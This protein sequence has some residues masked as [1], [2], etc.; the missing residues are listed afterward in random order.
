MKRI[1]F[2]GIKGIGKSIKEIRPGNIREKI[3]NN[4][5]KFAAVT[6][7][8]LA[9]IVGITAVRM[10]MPDG[11]EVSAATQNCTVMRQDLQK[12]L[13]VTGTIDGAGSYALSSPL[14]GVEVKSVNVKVGDRVRK[15]DVV[16][17]LDVS[18]VQNSIDSTLTGISANNEKNAM[19]IASA[20][21]SL[22]DAKTSADVANKR[23]QD[24]YEQAKADY[25]EAVKHRNGNSG[26]NGESGR[27]DADAAV[28]K[29]E[30]TVNSLITEARTAQDRLETLQKAYDDA[31]SDETK[32]ETDYNDAKGKY[33]GYKDQVDAQEKAV[34]D[35]E[36]GRDDALDAQD[37][38]EDNSGYRAYHAA[39]RTLRDA[40]SEL[41]SLKTKM[42]NAKTAMDKAKT[43]YDKA[44]VVTKDA[45]AAK[46][47]AEKK[48]EKIKYKQEDAESALS[49]AQTKQSDAKSD[50]DAVRSAQDNLTKASQ[51]V[52]D[53][54]RSGAKSVAE[55][56]D[57]IRS[58]ELSASTS[59]LSAQEELRKYREQAAKGVIV[60]LSDGV[61]TSLNVTE[62]G[63]YD[64]GTA[65][66][67][68]DDSG[69]KVSASI[70]QY[71]IA[72]ITTG[73]GAT[74]SVNNSEPLELAGNVTFVSPIPG[75]MAASSDGGSS[76]NAGSS[77][78]SSTSS[79]YPVEVMIMD[80]CDQLRLG[81]KVKLTI[82]LAEADD[83]LSVPANFIQTD[84][85][86][87]D[88]I[89]VVDGVTGSEDD[90]AEAEQPEEGA[91][92]QNTRIIYVTRGLETDYYVEISGDGLEENMEVVISD[93]TDDMGS[94]E[95][96]GDIAA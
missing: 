24:D 50:D 55:G 72:D 9:A 78:A 1:S 75:S 19:D 28:K 2:E 25:D 43:E 51:N 87:R 18:G 86:G 44:K 67:I 10:A 40:K 79:D 36:Y 13:S 29:A 77:S 46:E 74:I 49:K 27:S 34:R 20:R 69:Y 57:G 59:N 88:Y 96:M 94:G 70:G 61:V 17:V 85:E 52:S 5:K 41:K 58:A 63:M 83:V 12:T 32:K 93:V 84:E 3:R 8:T 26:I 48:L 35:A 81:M 56:L 68:Q 33:E 53:T 4:K 95:D 42:Q 73:L 15:G 16:A 80:Q 54:S 76:D 37:E 71:D 39:S 89:E 22:D 21:R 66:V 7:V 92:P 45:K 65:A 90:S 82:I 62:G 47:Q 91:E 64:G 23:A 60:A 14:T 11:S 6:A 38:S 31:Q 30:A